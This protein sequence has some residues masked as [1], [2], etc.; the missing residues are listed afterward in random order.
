MTSMLSEIKVSPDE[1]HHVCEDQPLYSSRFHSVLKYHP[2]GL[3]P[4]MDETGAFHIDLKGKPA[5][6]RRFKRTFGFYCSSAAVETEKG[7][8]HINPE[9]QFLYPEKYE[10]CGNYQENICVVRDKEG[11][12]FH[13]D[14]YGKRLY[15]ENYF[16]AGDFKDRIAV[17][18]DTK[19][20]SSHI[21]SQ[22]QFIH[23]K[24]YERLDVFHKGF[25]RAKDEKGWFHITKDGSPA[26]DHRFADVEP[27][28]NGQGYAQTL[29][30]DLVA[31]NENGE[32]IKE[33]SLSQKNFV[34]ELS[35]DL[36]GFW[37]KETI[38]VALELEILDL[39]PA[40]L[41]QIALKSKLPE[42]KVQRLL[43]VLGEIGLVEKNSDAW[44]LTPKGQLLVPSDKAF[45]AAAFDMWSKVQQEWSSLKEK[46]CQKSETH[47]P[48]FKEKTTDENELKI[49]RRALEGYA[50]ED[51][52]EVAT[53]PIWG[54]YQDLLVFGQTGITLLSEILKNNPS[55][56]GRLAHEERPL[57][58]LDLVDKSLQKRLK[59]FFIQYDQEWTFTAET[60]L[61]PRFLHYFPD[62]EALF[63]LKKTHQVLP[64][65]GKLHLFEMLLDSKGFGGGLLD[66]NMLVESGGKLRTFEQFQT[67]LNQAGFYAHEVQNVKPHLQYIQGEKQ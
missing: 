41:E 28:Y 34:G 56:Q 60:I 64:K 63:F 21:N 40:S 67:L 35:A 2:P 10:W 66:L 36:I 27:F 52:N 53:W 4:A 13:I 42:N 54:T 1:T 59:Q 51:F 16:Y 31:L 22:G 45:M 20:K 29:D 7:W 48:T 5:Y 46:L 19:G 44:S 18:C 62:Y 6:D 57:Y 58:H 61:M 49:Y 47:H 11:N 30:G 14:C 15:S 39:L 23:N 43:R 25:A 38:K 9:G 12:Y 17:V 24:W 50:R 3:A 8:G 37:K 65:G 26:Y 32:I 55:L 33:I